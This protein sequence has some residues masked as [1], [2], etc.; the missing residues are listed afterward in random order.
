MGQKGLIMLDTKVVVFGMDE[1][2][3]G[4]FNL[5]EEQIRLLDWLNNNN[6]FDDYFRYTVH[7]AVEDM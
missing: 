5:S 1:E 4:V 7:D 6:A 2:D 3:L